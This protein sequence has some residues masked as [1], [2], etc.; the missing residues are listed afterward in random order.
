MKRFARK[1]TAALLS[2]LLL[3][4]LMPFA[5]S[6]STP[7]T[8]GTALEIDLTPEEATLTFTPEAMGV[9]TLNIQNNNISIQ[10]ELFQGEDY[11]GH[12][13]FSG[14]LYA[15]Y[16][17]RGGEECRLAL[18]ADG[19]CA[20]T[21]TVESVPAIEA[22][23][24]QPFE[25]E[26]DDTYSAQY[27]FVTVEEDGYYLLSAEGGLVDVEA[28]S[29]T[30][31]P[32]SLKRNLFNLWLSQGAY[33][34]RVTQNACVDSTSFTLKKA[35]EA[36]AIT[37]EHGAPSTT[38]TLGNYYYPII[39]AEPLGATFEYREESDNQA[40]LQSTENGLLAVGLGTATVTVT[41]TNGLSASVKVTVA[42]PLAWD[43]KA[44]YTVVDK[45]HDVSVV[46]TPEESGTYV[47]ISDSKD[48]DP[49]VDLY[50]AYG[51]QIA[52]AD[53]NYGMNF[54][55]EVPLTA[56]E[57]YT[58]TF[59]NYRNGPAPYPVA[60]HLLNDDE[61]SSL[62]F[63]ADNFTV[64]LFS[65]FAP[66]LTLQPLGL[67]FY[68][69]VEFSS[70]NEDVIFVNEHGSMVAAGLGTATVTA[71]A[72]TEEGNLTATA[73]VTVTE[74]DTIQ[75]DVPVSVSVRN[76]Q[77]K[78][79]RFTAPKDGVYVF[80]SFASSGDPFL[81]VYDTDGERFMETDD[82]AG[83][84]DFYGTLEMSAGESVVL[85]ADDLQG[86]GTF[87]LVVATPVTATTMTASLWK[88]HYY[89][90]NG[91]T[92]YVDLNDMLYAAPV[93]VFGDTLGAEPEGYDF[94]LE[95][96]GSLLRSV[97]GDGELLVAKVGTSTITFESES[98]LSHTI[99][100]VVT[101][102]RILGDVNGD[103]KV[104]STDARMTLQYF[105]GSLDAD[106]LALSAADVNGD[107]N[108]D[109]T[110]A[111]LILQHFVGSITEFPR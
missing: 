15:T 5:V 85:S 66:D 42:A 99:T 104:D 19:N 69:Y 27:F 98:G 87:S 14:E 64:A 110:D 70:N 92:Y 61:P 38:V 46:I 88:D 1:L 55:L 58:L 97:Y 106:D 94:T 50:D 31:Y 57:S 45:G 91:D 71:T 54:I 39:T 95:S 103:T 30:A 20:A 53:D 77:P 9:Y 6:A 3:F 49:F 2:A 67:P 96:D 47:F 109:S 74:P 18:T 108:V 79:F 111:R 78:N 10:T 51:N 105:V 89:A 84:L 65:D 107:G 32:E 29:N 16:V 11:L 86:N 22:A 90:K 33:A 21:V 37:L 35:P 26:W 56:G 73:T 76:R 83:G 25:M 81:Y 23:L 72:V 68:G 52:G 48:S 12:E 101:D 41:T 75:P 63:E 93:V 34:F 28:L 102:G 100:V 43:M 4:S 80:R 24:D 62:A 8:I 13:W 59:G 82:S 60:A 7:L 17:L 36:T 44:P 40:V